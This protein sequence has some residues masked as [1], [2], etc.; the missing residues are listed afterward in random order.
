M[1]PHRARSSLAWLLA[2]SYGLRVW[3][4]CLGGQG[5]WADE[6]RYV[7][8][9]NAAAELL[10]GQ[11]SMAAHEL[12]R[13]DHTLFRWFALPPGLFETLAGTHPAVVASYFG[14]FSVLAIFL[15]WAVA[16]RA[17]AGEDE[18]LWAAYLAAGANCLFYYSRHFFPYDVS[19]ALMLGSLWLA[20]GPWS[21]RN[22]LVVGLVAGAGFLTYNGYWLLGGCVLILHSLL[23]AGGGR[24]L[25]SRAALSGG[26]LLLAILPI[27][28]LAR[29]LGRNLVA[30]GSQW[31]ALVRGD[32]PYGHRVIAGY[33]W[34]SE[35]GVG[36]LWLAAFAYALAQVRRDRHWGRMAWYAGG[37]GVVLGGL[38]VLSDL[39]PVFRV[40][41]RQVR[42]LVPFLCLGAAFGIARLVER[43]GPVRSRWAAAIALLAGG[44]AA[45]NFSVPLGQVFPREFQERSARIIAQAAGPDAYRLAFAESLWGLPLNPVLPASPPLLRAAHPMQFIPFQ[46][47]GYD[48]AQRAEISRHD[49]SMRLFRIPADLAG[50]AARGGGYSG[51]VRWSV[52]F[53]TDRASL[54]EPLVTSG[55]PGRGDFLFVR[56]LDR[57]HVAFGLDH[58][59]G[60]ELISLP[61]EIDYGTSHDLVLSLGSLLGPAAG[62]PAPSDPELARWRDQVLVTFDGRVVLRHAQAAWPSGPAEVM[63]GVNLIGGSAA[64]LTFSGRVLKLD[65]APRGQV[66]AAMNGPE[67]GGPAE[68]SWIRDWVPGAPLEV[69]RADDAGLSLRNIPGRGESVAAL[70]FRLPAPAERRAQP[71]M[72]FSRKDG[73]QG[74]LAIRRAAAGPEIGWRDAQ[75]WWWSG[76]LVGSAGDLHTVELQWNGAGVAAASPGA[77]RSRRLA[78][79]IMLD[80]RFY[81]HP[82]PQFFDIPSAESLNWRD[83]DPTDTGVA[84]S[85]T[86]EVESAPEVVALPLVRDGPPAGRHFRLA[87]RFPDDRPGRN[88][89]LVIAGRAGAADGL[90]VHYERPGWVRLGF[91]HWGVGGPLSAPVAVTAGAY[92]ILGVEL[93]AGSWENPEGRDV[94]VSLDGQPVLQ[95]AASCYPVAPA[96]VAI[97]RNG[98]HLSTSDP[99][100]FGEI[101]PLVDAG[102]LP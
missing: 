49:I 47:E 26:G 35:G 98:I 2:V 53:P 58:W 33:L 38:L 78:A 6:D 11:W 29:V 99:V 100:F 80:G 60:G 92:Q 87:V 67:V 21:W 25:V 56:Y 16:R 10:R 1:N 45:W 59:G 76:P 48:K 71:L 97:G 37:L 20:L 101:F 36:V 18:A 3:L 7:D 42:D 28:E 30:E 94:R 90:F 5:F 84:G 61:V 68:S 62:G 22:S 4:A 44:G 93:A 102:P 81:P 73:A 75:G 14:L 82:R 79:M 52:V 46:Y 95:A 66:S 8:G 32:F 89:P 86:G 77:E 83:P 85:F 74:L 65:P 27:V 64:Q 43:R 72:A 13:S 96:D 88:E 12:F 55:R 70:R 54:A 24:R 9:H 23:G 63:F 57:R 19:L 17:G 39:V 34:Y 69:N 31:G 50:A 15:V 41:G 40:Q 91:D 51:P